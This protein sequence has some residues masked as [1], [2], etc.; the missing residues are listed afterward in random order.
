MSH[1]PEVINSVAFS[2]WV[3]DLDILHQLVIPTET[4]SVTDLNWHFDLPFWWS[5]VGYPGSGRYDIK[6][7]QVLELHAKSRPETYSTDYEAA[8]WRHYDLTMRTDYQN[9][10]LDIVWYKDHWLFLD[11]LHRLLHAVIDGQ[12]DVTVRKLTKEFAEKIL[13]DEKSLPSDLE[14]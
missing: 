6:P 4:M 14:L 9:Y 1:V 7:N 11:G 12:Q 8:L 3:W 5:K 2:E 10:P 13:L